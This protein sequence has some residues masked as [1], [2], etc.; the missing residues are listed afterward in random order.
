MAQYFILMV[1]GIALSACGKKGPV[2]SLEPSKYPRTYPKPSSSL[3]IQK[4]EP[5]NDA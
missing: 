3:N 5:S 2:E 4:K 1:L